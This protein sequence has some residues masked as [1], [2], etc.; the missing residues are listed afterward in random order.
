MV[1]ESGPVMMIRPG[2]SQ[3]PPRMVSGGHGLA[4]AGERGAQGAVRAWAK[5]CK[6]DVEA[7]R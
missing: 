6:H 1:T 3:E 5:D 2:V 4:V 7:G